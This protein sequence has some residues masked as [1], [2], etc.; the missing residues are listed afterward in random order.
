MHKVTQLPD[1]WRKA[2]PRKSGSKPALQPHKGPRAG[3]S[4]SIASALSAPHSP[5][6]STPPPWRRATHNKGQGEGRPT[7]PGPAKRA[8][9]PPAGRQGMVS[10][11]LLPSVQKQSPSRLARWAGRKRGAPGPAQGFREAAGGCALRPP[12]GAVRRGA[13]GGPLAGPPARPPARRPRRPRWAAASSRSHPAS[14]GRS[15]A[16]RKHPGAAEGAGGRARGGSGI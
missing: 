1:G 7:R 16:S 8:A 3:T 5:A 14:R 10:S 12:P 15:S 2:D 9:W 6:E 11:V 4:D 13:P